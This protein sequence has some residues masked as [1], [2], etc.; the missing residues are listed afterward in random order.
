V[1]FV[2]RHI[3]DLNIQTFRGIKDLELK[4]L[5]DI[6]IIVGANNCGKTSALEAIML[7]S[8][9]GDFSNVVSIARLREASRNSPRMSVSFYDSFLYLFNRL[10]EELVISISGIINEKYIS[11]KTT[12]RVEKMLIDAN[13]IIKRYQTG[14]QRLNEEAINESEEVD[15]FVGEIQFENGEISLI[16][17]LTTVVFNKYERVMPIEIRKAFLNMTFISAIDHIVKNIF[18]NIV[19]NKKF[20]SQVVEILRIFDPNIEDLRIIVDDHGRITQVI[21]DLLLGDMPLSSY[22]D[23]IK[24]VI[25]LASGIVEAKDGV[26]LIDEIETSIHTSALKNVFAWLIYACK[27]FN[28][29]LFLTTH[30]LETV[31]AMLNCIGNDRND[32]LI[33]VITLVKKENKTVARVLTGEKA[34]QVRDEYDMELRS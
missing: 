33:R 20:R 4:N 12:G 22:G 34:L 27:E 30:S 7:L 10:N 23:G 32:D 29:Q 24:K 9:P 8:R 1:L 6:N 5:G 13:E 18:R 3:S 19:K 16:P 15:S 25:A 11:S 2:A 14:K 28:V 26:L 31:D 21:E 17:N